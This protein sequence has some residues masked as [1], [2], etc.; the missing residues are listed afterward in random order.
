MVVA[1]AKAGFLRGE[2][3]KALPRVQEIPFDSDRK[4][5]TTIHRMMDRRDTSATTFAYPP[6]IAFVKGAPDVIL[7][8]CTSQAA[9]GTAVATDAGT[10][11][12]KCSSKT[13]I[14][15]ATR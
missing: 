3:G 4:R 11:R 8:L 15:R 1:A 12:R 7:D 10:S 2:L 13:A 14:W 6:F 9:G 5:M